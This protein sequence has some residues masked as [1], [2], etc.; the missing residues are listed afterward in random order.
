MYSDIVLKV[1]SVSK[2]FDLFD[3]Q[4]DKLKK[5]A[6]EL[7]NKKNTSNKV[8]QALND[9]SFEAR[10]GEAIG[11]L[12]K[13]GAGKST[14]L[15]LICGTL[16]P[17]KG[18]IN[19]VGRLAALLELG[20]GFNPEFTGRENIFINSAILGLNRN[21]IKEKFD[22]IV[23]FADIGDFLDQPVKHYSSGMFMRLAFSVASSVE[24]DILIVDEALAVGDARFQ[25]KCFRR[26]E[27]LRE[28]GTTILLVT[29]STEQITRHCSKAL[30]IDR[31]HMVAFGEA[32]KVCNQYLELLFGKT[33]TNLPISE[34]NNPKVIEHDNNQFDLQNLENSIYYNPHEHKWGNGEAEIIDFHI[35]QNKKIN[36][37]IISSEYSLN[38]IFHARF[39][40]D[41]DNVI[42]GLT[43]KT[44]DGVT[45][46]GRNTKGELGTELLQKLNSQEIR[47]V[48]FS[49]N[50]KLGTGDYTLSLGIVKEVDGEIIPM[51]RRYD[52]I[53]VHVE[54]NSLS[55]GIVDLYEKI[56]VSNCEL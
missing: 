43:L 32:N 40:V 33:T 38:V 46:F 28:K 4:K 54:S 56:E 35:I 52:S 11:V 27:K 14:L 18:N 48:S 16:T 37:T 3:T 19:V 17:T 31:G 45:I 41:V 9:I 2:H 29:H 10:K 47:K 51:E 53:L 22:D 26:L 34:R 7:L 5:L 15:Q 6:R 50:A 12:G 25:A 8:Y 42:F 13:N 44:K 23:K 36:P 39:N 20:A 1:D 55:Y 30:L 49:I 24:P 21:E